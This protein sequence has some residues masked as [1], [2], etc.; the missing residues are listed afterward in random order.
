LRQI[1]AAAGHAAGQSAIGEQLAGQH[2][3]IA[4][5]I[6]LAVKRGVNACR[7]IAA[8]L[9]EARGEVPGMAGDLGGAGGQVG[10]GILRRRQRGVDA[11]RGHAADAD[12]AVLDPRGQRR[13]PGG[14]DQ[15]E[16]IRRQRPRHAHVRPVQH[17][18]AGIDLA[19]KQGA[20]SHAQAKLGD[21]YGDAA[22]GLVDGDVGGRQH[23]LWQQFQRHRPGDANLA[24]HPI[25]RQ[26]REIIAVTVPVE[27]R[28][29]QPGRQQQCDGEQCQEGR[30][31][32]G[33]TH[34]AQ[35]VAP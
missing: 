16:R 3:P 10:A 17:Q 14:R 33:V 34:P 13:Q 25:G 19:T 6:A 22:A 23:R 1:R 30:E 18:F 20:E 26:S 32:A 11:G 7:T 12:A 15:F 27:H 29:H 21:R 9:A 28:R 4:L 35:T 8:G 2:G 31:P 24:P 5:H